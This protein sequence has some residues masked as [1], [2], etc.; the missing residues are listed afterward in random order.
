MSDCLLQK[1][2]FMF[3]LFMF[4]TD[5]VAV[6]NNAKTTFKTMWTQIQLNQS[7][8]SIK[9]SWTLV[10]ISVVKHTW[11][12]F[13][14]CLREWR[15]SCHKYRSPARDSAQWYLGWKSNVKFIRVV[16]QMVHLEKFSLKFLMFSF[17][18]HLGHKNLCSFLLYYYLSDFFFTFSIPVL[19]FWCFSQRWLCTSQN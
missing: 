6:L 14:K 15:R 4:R 17:V 19:L 3:C 9:L 2:F 8:Q 11:N 10:L 13:L 16:P 1:H 5:L 18:I 7:S 12:L